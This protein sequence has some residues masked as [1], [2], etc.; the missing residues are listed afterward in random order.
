MRFMGQWGC[1]DPPIDDGVEVEQLLQP[2]RCL[3]Q[4]HELVCTAEASKTFLHGKMTL[5]FF[6]FFRQCFRNFLRDGSSCIDSRQTEGSYCLF[7]PRWHYCATGSSHSVAR[8]TF[9]Q[10]FR[11]D[12]EFR[13]GRTGSQNPGSPPPR[14]LQ[15]ADLGSFHSAALEQNEDCSWMLCDAL[16]LKAGDQTSRK[17]FVFCDAAL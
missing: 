15:T 13:S 1:S 2:V 8:E 11:E 14:K 12:T 5:M 10:I 3:R 7:L 17:R 9:L 16:S 4:K 6:R